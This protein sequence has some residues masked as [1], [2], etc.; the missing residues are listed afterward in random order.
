[1]R[2]L[3]VAAGAQQEALRWAKDH[4]ATPQANPPAALA[5][6]T[7][8]TLARVLLAT[9]EGAAVPGIIRPLLEQAEAAGRTQSVI[10][11]ALLLARARLRRVGTRPR[12]APGWRVPCIWPR[13]QA[14]CASSW[15]RAQHCATCCA[16]CAGR[17]RPYVAGL[18]AAL[19]PDAPTAPLAD[20]P[21][22]LSEQELRVLRLI[23]A[24]KSNREIAEELVITVGTAKWHV[25]NVLQKLGVGSRPQAIARARELG[26]E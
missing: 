9:G 2:G 23:V 22:P 3:Q 6:F 12:R 20:L 5:E 7:A 19:T 18:L 26:F 4:Q 11:G 21:E 24:G 17:R 16:A 8:F 14:M 15:T 1:V 25:H 10:E 13:R